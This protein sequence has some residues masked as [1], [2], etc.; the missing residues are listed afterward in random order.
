MHCPYKHTL[1]PA[2]CTNVVLPSSGKVQ[3]RL[4]PKEN[5]ITAIRKVCY[6]CIYYLTQH[7]TPEDLNLQDKTN[8][9]LTIIQTSPQKDK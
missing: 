8:F 7:N 2:F 1:L 9:L 6:Y 3:G 4:G 5:Y